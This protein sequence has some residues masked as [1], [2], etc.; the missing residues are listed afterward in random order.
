MNPIFLDTETT[1]IDENARLIELWYIF[2]WEIHEFLFNPWVPIPPEASEVHHIT[3]E[4]IEDEETFFGS[5]QKKDLQIILDDN[6]LVAHN[7]KFDIWIL[8][9]EWVTVNRYIDTLRVAQHLLPDEKKHS[10]QYLNYSLGLYREIKIKV[11][12]HSAKY[13]I[14]VLQK[15]FDKL[16]FMFPD[17]IMLDDEIIYEKMIELS[18]KPILLREIKFWK[19]IWKTFEEVSWNDIWYLRWL[20]DSESSKVKE[21]QNENMI[22]TLKHYLV[23]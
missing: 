23:K 13:D 15:L 16:M 12:P 2:D 14:C 21:Q 5:K 11:K 10:L 18:Q 4:M 1:W 7:A 19:H 3:N 22:H 20:L 9:R 8:E 6:I 17:S